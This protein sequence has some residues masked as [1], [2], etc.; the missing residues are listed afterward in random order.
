MKTHNTTQVNKLEITADKTQIAA[1]G[2]SQIRV[3]DVNSNDPQ[4]VN[5][6][7]G[8]NGNVTALGFQKDTKWM[9][10]GTTTIHFSL[11]ARLL[12]HTDTFTNNHT[13]SHNLTRV[14]RHC[15]R[16]YGYVQRS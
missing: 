7:E 2:N 10:S 1:A 6:F 14:S 16:I 3:Y 13:N 4:P 12:V 15:L 8:H 11:L 9:Y 5:S